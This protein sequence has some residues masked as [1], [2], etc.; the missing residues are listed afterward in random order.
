LA[1]SEFMHGYRLSSS[2]D[3]KLLDEAAAHLTNAVTRDPGFSLAHATLSF[4]WA[5]R[6]FEY[7]PARTWLERAGIPLPARA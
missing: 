6:H 4:V 7:D 2:G 3:P 1:Y 5:T